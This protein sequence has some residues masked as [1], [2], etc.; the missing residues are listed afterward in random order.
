MNYTF[1]L[2]AH[3]VDGIEITQLDDPGR[4]SL[5]QPVALD[6][7]KTATLSNGLAGIATTAAEEWL[8]TD[9]PDLGTLVNDAAG[10]GFTVSF[11]VEMASLNANQTIIGWTAPGSNA[12]E[13]WIGA[14][15]DGDL[16]IY[17][18]APGPVLN[19]IDT[20]PVFQPGKPALVTVGFAEGVATAWV[21]GLM[22]LVDKPFA[23]TTPTIAATRFAI[24]ARDQNTDTQ[25]FEGKLHM[26]E[27]TTG[28]AL[29]T[30]RAHLSRLL[31]GEIVDVFLMHGIGQSMVGGATPSTNPIPF[32]CADGVAWAIDQRP[33]FNGQI[34]G[35][36]K[37]G[38]PSSVHFGPSAGWPH[39]AQ[40]LFDLTGI[41]T[42]W[43]NYAV[44]GTQ[45]VEASRPTSALIW[46][47]AN[48]AK[49]L[50]GDYIYADGGEVLTRRQMIHD[51]ADAIRLNP[52][53]NAIAKVVFMRH[54]HADA[55]HG[56]G[57]GRIVQAD[58][59][60]ELNALFDYMQAEFGIDLFLLDEVGRVGLDA[61]TVAANEPF[62][63]PIRA[64]QHAVVAA[65]ADTLMMFTGA[66]EFGPLVVDA[67][68][69][70]VSGWDLQG[71][72]IH[73]TAESHRCM[74]LTWARA[75]AD[76]LA[77]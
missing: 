3:V 57:G 25:G 70:H 67:D 42:V 15:A 63:A 29:E 13:M 54:G 77:E 44:A 49:C 12:D 6:R 39:M 68:G 41:P 69:Y 23:A 14:N 31:P 9:A 72:G 74:G 22:V 1:A 37:N 2:A 76:Y 28:D 43:C 21:N 34:S 50:A 20:A 55:T 24:G 73:D 11:L 51:A 17:R 61:A 32:A 47:P 18:E 30:H 19:V 48:M 38:K 16:R 35:P 40:R 7:P 4:A 27:I 5:V 52:K 8:Y 60:R 26:V 10:M 33:G 75:F 71:D 59:E 56:I 64:A 58:Y 53:F 46:S 36:F 65:R 45:L 66:K 62:F